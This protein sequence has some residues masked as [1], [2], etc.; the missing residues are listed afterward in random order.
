MPAKGGNPK[1]IGRYWLAHLFELE[2]DGRIVMRRF[3]IHIEHQAVE[4]EAR[5]ANSNTV[6]DGEIA[7]CHNDIHPTQLPE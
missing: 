6:S 7:R 3:F 2:I 1:I 5:R 4:D